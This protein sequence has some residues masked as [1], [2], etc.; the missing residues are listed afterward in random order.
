MIAVI[1]FAF[2]LVGAIELYFW[3]ERA[4]KEILV[5]VLLLGLVTTMAVLIHL[6]PD[7]PVP[8]PFAFLEKLLLRLWQGGSA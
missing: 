1:I 8:E 4:W 6:I 2:L 5:Y 3:P 7:L